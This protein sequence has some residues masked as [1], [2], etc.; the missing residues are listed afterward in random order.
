[1][2][3]N[4]NVN[5]SKDNYSGTLSERWRIRLNEATIYINFV[6]KGK[7]VFSQIIIHLII[8]IKNFV[9]QRLLVVKQSMIFPHY[10][11]LAKNGKSKSFLM[12]RFRRWTP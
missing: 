4:K 2:H 8:F 12:T 5:F 11:I 3:F 9:Y 6:R 7:D 10:C 1:M